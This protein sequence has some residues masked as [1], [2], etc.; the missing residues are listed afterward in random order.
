MIQATALDGT[1]VRV[2]EECALQAKYLLRARLTCAWRG[3][4][5]RARV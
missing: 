3:D 5:F 2:F 4:D 1:F